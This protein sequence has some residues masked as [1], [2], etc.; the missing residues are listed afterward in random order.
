MYCMEGN[1]GVTKI[2]WNWRSTKNLPNFHHSK[3]YAFIKSHVNIK[4]MDWKIFL[5]HMPN[6]L[7]LGYHRSPLDI[8]GLWIVWTSRSQSK[9]PPAKGLSHSCRLVITVASN[10]WIYTKC[11]TCHFTLTIKLPDIVAIHM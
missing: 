5:R 11:V 8:H 9:S 2:W 6:N 1:F 10:H 3:F 4:Q 7:Q